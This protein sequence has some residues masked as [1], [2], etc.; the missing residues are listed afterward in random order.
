MIKSHE[1]TS[2]EDPSPTISIITANV[3]KNGYIDRSLW[4]RTF[5]VW[6]S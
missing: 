4:I 1:V 6:Q 3:F 2:L 5:A